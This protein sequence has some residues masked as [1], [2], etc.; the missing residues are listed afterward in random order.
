[1]NFSNKAMSKVS[2]P[3]VALSKSAKVIPVI[4]VGTLRG[5]YTPTIKNYAVAFTIT[6]GLIM[7]NYAK[8]KS[9]KGGEDKD[10]TIGIVLVLASLLFDGLT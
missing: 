4:L 1:M 6:T 3:L 5:V 9:K 10:N 2:F 8:M 7:F